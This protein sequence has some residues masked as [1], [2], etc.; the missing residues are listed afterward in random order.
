MTT[1]FVRKDGNDT[2]GDGSTGTP[3]LTLSKAIASV[4]AGSIVKIGAGTY[5]EDALFNPT[6]NFA[7]NT[8]FES[9]SGVN[10]DV[11]IT[12]NHAT[13]DTMISD[14]ARYFEF[15]NV[16]F[17]KRI[18]GT[19]AAVRIADCSYITFTN[20]IFAP[21]S[22]A[23]TNNLVRIL[24]GGGTGISNI[25]FTNCT[26]PETGG[27]AIK[28]DGIAG[29]TTT[30]I[31]L[32]NC[33][34]ASSPNPIQISVAQPTGAFVITGGSYTA[35]TNQ[36]LICD[37]CDSMTI[38]G[39]TFISPG[40]TVVSINSDN[41]VTMSLVS[42]TNVTVQATG[43]A[44]Y[45]CVISGPITDLLVSGGSYTAI[46]APALQIGEDAIS[47][48]EINS[49]Q[50]INATVQ[51]STSHACLLGGGVVSLAASGLVVRG[52]DYG[53]VVKDNDGTSIVNSNLSGGSLGTLYFKAA[54]NATATGNTITNTAGYCVQ[55]LKDD[56]DNKCQ[57]V[58]VTNNRI[59]GTGTNGLLRLMTDADDLGG[60]VFDYNKYKPRGSAK[61][62]AVR[63]DTDG[64]VTLAE[65]RAA[66][67]GYGDG[68][69]DSH[70]SLIVDDDAAVW[71]MLR[72]RR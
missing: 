5:A 20:C 6:Q 18:A 21:A 36:A 2:T 42:L 54:T 16:T 17:A 60:S 19:N 52:G 69:N 33:T 24:G 46:G 28:V 38:N 12:G 57:N 10:T 32:T 11:I 51:S 59:M 39:A 3:W 25:T 40:N 66:W 9:E 44:N 27:P 50:L 48:D 70:S 23:D 41:L 49:G 68:S 34:V 15:K 47:T 26:F 14:G 1:Y 65:L 71:F 67:T 37:N 8:V 43:A 30:G 35:T 64:M 61:F 62:G 56:L 4:S 13:Y 7:S 72:R 53:V 58:V 55:L 29:K 45:G 31:T 22:A 63:A